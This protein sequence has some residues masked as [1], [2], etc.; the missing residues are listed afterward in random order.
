[1]KRFGL[2]GDYAVYAF[3]I[4]YGPTATEFEIP[5]YK[6]H[7]NFVG[8]FNV[9][10]ALAVI[11]AA[12]HC[13]LSN[14]QI[15]SAFDTFKG[16]KRRMEVRGI[17]GGVTVIDDFGHHPTAIR[18]TLRA[19]RQKYARE[20]IWAVFEPRSN[21]TR[22]NVFQKEL[23][24]S[25]AD[26]DAVVIAQVARLE[27]LAPEERLN[28]GK[29]I[30]DLNAA[31]KEAAYLPDADAI[32]AHVGGGAQGGDIVCVFSN[33]GFGGIHGKLLERLGRR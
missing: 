3:N 17:A 15:Q 5:S 6:F 2:G 19:L 1:V 31:G 11:G 33:G 29:L 13:G 16:I 24:G 9:R 8:E 7:L 10:N 32:V 14:K 30:E 22:R 18:E 4:R 21:T 26:A 12:K 27:Q 20:K 25:F 23:A 28:P